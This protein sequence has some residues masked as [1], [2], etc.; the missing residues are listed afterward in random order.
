MK[1]NKELD[2]TYQIVSKI[3]SKPVPL[4]SEL[5]NPFAANKRKQK[6]L[7]NPNEKKDNTLPDDVSLWNTKSFV[8]YFAELYF[9]QTGGTYK[10]TYASDNSIFAE[11]G[12]FMTSNGLQ[13][14]EWT[15]KFIDWS[16]QQRE[17]IIKKSGHF[18]PATIR[19]YLNHFYQEEVIPKIE[20]DTI[21][22]SYF[23]ST[24]LDDIK[25]ADE[26]GKSSE[27][28]LRFGIPIA[29]TYY[30]QY[31][32]FKLET[33]EKGLALFIKSLASGNV[34]SKE[35]LSQMFQRSIMKSPYPE[36]FSE[37]DWRVK[38]KQ[39]CDKYSKENWWREQDYKGKPLSEYNKLLKRD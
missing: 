37:L 6:L 22:R 24:I 19:N 12:K 9:T 14:Q 27:I 3:M 34:E 33:V 8:N 30:L 38:Y 20:E 7:L 5:T 13:K 4:Q 18:L 32:G 36:D 10:K 1:S 17:L 11:I 35:K 26:E 2:P 15:K 25:E 16:F 31:R 21:E 39:Y 29:S 23:E 28:Y